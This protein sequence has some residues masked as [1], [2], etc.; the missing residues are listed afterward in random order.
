MA[1]IIAQLNFASVRQWVDAKRS[2]E[3]TRGVTSVEVKSLSPRSATL[4]IN[5][6]GDIGSLRQSLQQVGLNLNDPQTAYGQVNGSP[7]YQ[8]TQG[9]RASAY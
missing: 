5:F 6:Q 1:N 4:S 2:V 9:F 7:I 3:Q 8:L